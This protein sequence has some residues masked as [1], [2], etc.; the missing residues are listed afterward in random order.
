MVVI[1]GEQKLTLEERV[2][3][4]QEEVADLEALQDMNDQLVESNAELEADLREELDMAQSAIREVCI[5]YKTFVYARIKLYLISFFRHNV[6][7]MLPLK[8]LPIEN[9]RLVNLEI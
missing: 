4:L 9:K 2:A 7:E 3:Q 8:Q 1:L 6:I 5:Y